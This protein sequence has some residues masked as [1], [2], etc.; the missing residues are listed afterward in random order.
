MKNTNLKIYVVT[1][2]S[3]A[4]Y[5]RAD[6]SI[7]A[8]SFGDALKQAIKHIK[9]ISTECQENMAVDELKRHSAPTAI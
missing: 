1:Y 6:R 5:F 2:E 7:K 4:N 9:A 8:R 3:T